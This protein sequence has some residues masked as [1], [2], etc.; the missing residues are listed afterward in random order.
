MKTANTTVTFCRFI[1]ILILP[2][3]LFAAPGDLDP[4]FGTSGIVSINSALSQT[5]YRGVREFPDG[6]LLV[7][8]GGEYIAAKKYTASGVSVFYY[9]TFAYQGNNELNVPYVKGTVYDAEIT[10]S[11]DVYFA[12]EVKESPRGDSRPAIWKFLANGHLDTSWG[13]SGRIFLSSAE[14]LATQ[15]EERNTKLYVLYSVSGQRYVTRRFV[16]NGN[17]DTSFGTLGQTAVAT[18]ASQQTG[19]MIIS[20]STGKI[21]IAS[22]PLLR[23]NANGSI[24]NTFGVNGIASPLPVYDNCPGLEET[25]GPFGFNSVSFNSDGTLFVAARSG[26]TIAEAYVAFSGVSKYSANGVLDTSFNNGQIGCGGALFGAVFPMV[27]NQADGKVFLSGPIVTRFNI[28]GSKDLTYPSIQA[29]PND[30][31]VQ[32]IDGKNVVLYA[33]ELHR[34]LP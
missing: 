18:G 6:Q 3:A 13:T 32:S 22:G 33:H 17:F 15:I 31:L 12:G 14:G 25:V 24:D 9:G 23:L 2:V 21:Y 29:F 34:R 7:F 30:L 26:V 16:S 10:P 5:T 28:D 1:L 8:G 19:G 4:T 11:G 27:A 20:T